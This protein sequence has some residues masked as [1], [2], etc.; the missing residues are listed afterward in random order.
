M[1]KSI[2]YIL[3]IALSLST[4]AMAFD[5]KNDKGELKRTPPPKVD[6]PWRIDPIRITDHWGDGIEHPPHH[7]YHEHIHPLCSC[8]GTVH[9]PLDKLRIYQPQE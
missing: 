5:I 8:I 9:I 3:L 6:G 2:K 7:R 1:G 4:P